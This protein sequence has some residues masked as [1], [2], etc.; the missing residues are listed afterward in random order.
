M[1]YKDRNDSSVLFAHDFHVGAISLE[2]FL[3][4]QNVITQ[5]FVWTLVVQIAAALR[6]IH[7]RQLAA[8]CLSA[9]NI[10]LCS[11]DRGGWILTESCVR[12]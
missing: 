9:K 1:T 12:T 8:R 5:E 3:Q 2:K 11:Y 4:Q 10:L 7:G 6:A